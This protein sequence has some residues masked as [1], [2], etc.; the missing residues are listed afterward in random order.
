MSHKCRRAYGLALAVVL[1]AQSV[2]AQEVDPQ[3]AVTAGQVA[4]VAGAAAMLGVGLIL[5]AH[6]GPPSCAPCDPLTVPAFDRWIIR[7]PVQ[8]FSTA[9]D[10]LVIGV[11]AGTMAHTATGS[12]GWRGVAVQVET[13][14][15]TI[16][17][18]EVSKALIGRK[19]P[20]LYTADAATVAGEVKNQRS[21][22]SGH[23]AA[24]FAL[25]T[26]YWVNNPDVGLGPKIVAMA[27][28]AG[29]GVLRVAAAKH[30][31][32]DVVI[33][34]LLGSATALAVHQIRF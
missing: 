24:A 18:T 30:F 19:R 6:Q 32:S 23:T 29:V 8:G 10:V 15:W 12:S 17:I 28:A 22:P 9:S 11:A 27:G 31:P 25:A 2:A 14:A 4:S 5:D 1:L 13:L 21:M 34:A 7:Q 33:G 20:V 3:P 16:G 26:S